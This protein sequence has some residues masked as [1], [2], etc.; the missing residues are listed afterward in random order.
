MKVSIIVNGIGEAY[1]NYIYII[2]FVF[3]KA[4][5]NNFIYTDYTYS[6]NLFRLLGY[7]I[8]YKKANV[9]IIEGARCFY[10]Y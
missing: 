4:V 9:Y 1:L 6:Y 8:I 3:F 5:F 10:H 7:T 2:Y